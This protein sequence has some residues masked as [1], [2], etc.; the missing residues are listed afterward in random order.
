M[1]QRRLLLFGCRILASNWLRI[2]CRSCCLHMKEIGKLP[3]PLKLIGP[4]SCALTVFNRILMSWTVY[5]VTVL[6]S[7]KLTE[8]AL[9]LENLNN[10][11]LH[12][13]YTPCKPCNSLQQHLFFGAII[14]K[15]KWIY[16]FSVVIRLL[17]PKKSYHNLSRLRYPRWKSKALTAVER[18][19]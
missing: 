11:Q 5:L 8:Y 10:F 6:A 2:G 3:G 4:S 15:F 13:L 19:H 12:K 1:G 7:K 14:I 16:R 17:I 9:D 18:I